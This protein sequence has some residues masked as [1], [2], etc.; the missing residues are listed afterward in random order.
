MPPVRTRLAVG[1]VSLAV[2]G[3][4]LVLMR[5]L[6]LRYWHHFAYL[7]ISV[8]LLGFG[9]SG[10][11]LAL[12]SR[13]VEGWWREWLAGAALLFALAVPAVRW[14]ARAVPLDVQ[15]LSWDLGQAGYV[16]L[17]E[18]LLL[19]PFFFGG[20]V[21]GLALMDEPRRIGGHYAA[22]LVGSGLG[23]VAAVMLM[24]VLP[25]EDLFIV[26]A[27]AAFL[28]GAI[29]MPWYRPGGV[30]AVLLTA[31][32]L[33]HLYALAPREPLFSPYKT[34]PQSL[35]VP[36]T[37]VI[38]QDEVRPGAESSVHRPAAAARGDDS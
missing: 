3:I 17:L 10:T 15:F 25:A 30:A 34:L 21:V 11:V 23:G 35:A 14:L 26:M 6:S 28:G 5:S 19:V 1:L 27:G 12:L 31:V 9:A 33:V 13:R 4:E 20:A 38:C 22:N 16:G 2:V 36:G 37:E 29:I 18:L 32:G 7:V 8:A 24:H